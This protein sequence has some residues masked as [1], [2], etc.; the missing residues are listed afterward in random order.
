MHRSSMSNFIFSFSHPPSQ[1]FHRDVV[2]QSS[3]GYSNLFFFQCL[4]GLLG[5][6]S[7]EELEQVAFLVEL[8][9]CLLADDVYG[10]DPCVPLQLVEVSREATS[11][12]DPIVRLSE[13]LLDCAHLVLD[14]CIRPCL[15]Q[16]S[17]HLFVE[18]LDQICM[19]L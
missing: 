14:P 3:Q 18:W 9:G 10:E 4:I 8:A 5:S 17:V 11:T 13:A 15:S 7:A 19:G 6:V 1:R 2:Q 12:T 16:R